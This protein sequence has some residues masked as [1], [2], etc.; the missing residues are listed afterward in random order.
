MWT[1]LFRH[2][3]SFRP[4]WLFYPQF[5]S[6]L[7]IQR[8]IHSVDGL[9]N[10]YYWICCRLWINWTENIHPSKKKKKIMAWSHSLFKISGTP[11]TKSD[12]SNHF[13]VTHGRMFS[14]QSEKVLCDCKN[15]DML[16]I[17]N[18]LGNHAHLKYA[19]VVL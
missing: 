3:C 15:F 5:S 7:M 10:H 13:T 8:V 6:G 16:Q 1:T 17:S 19:G 14:T 18:L 4:L 9:H 2:C 11:L 12:W